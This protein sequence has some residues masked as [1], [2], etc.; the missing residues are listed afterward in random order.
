MSSASGSAESVSSEDSDSPYYDANASPLS[1]LSGTEVAAFGMT[2]AGPEL[3]VRG[4]AKGPIFPDG[5]PDQEILSQAFRLM[6]AHWKKQP[7]PSCWD[8]VTFRYTSEGAPELLR[9]LIFDTEGMYYGCFRGEDSLN[10]EWNPATKALTLRL[11]A[12][13]VHDEVRRELEFALDKELDRIAQEIPHLRDLRKKLRFCDLGVLIP[14][15]IKCPDDQLRFEDRTAPTF[16]VEVAYTQGE[17]EQLRF[18]SFEPYFYQSPCTLL[19]IDIDY[20]D[21]H[22]VQTGCSSFSLWAT[23]TNEDEDSF[24]LFLDSRRIF[25]QNNQALPGELVIPFR[26]L[27]PP[28]ERNID[29]LDDAELRIPYE[30]MSGWVTKAIELY[31]DETPHNSESELAERWRQGRPFVESEGHSFDC[32]SVTTALSVTLSTG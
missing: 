2:E 5:T 25:R 4:L 17:R 11:L 18:E 27:L 7:L 32:K 26:Y 3:E 29:G 10:M 9:S 16:I 31:K 22:G 24:N 19:M 30:D 21:E 13:I 23:T 14:G 6:W 12:S 20:P 15:G 8:Y 1:C 28:S